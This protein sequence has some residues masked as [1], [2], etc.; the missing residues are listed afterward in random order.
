[1]RALPHRRVWALR[2]EHRSQVRAWAC[3]AA[4]TVHALL[5]AGTHTAGQADL[6][7]GQSWASGYNFTRVH[8]FH[9]DICKWSR[10]CG[11]HAR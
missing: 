11:A 6:S 7:A 9:S 2:G 1:V 10:L 4:R 8:S 5:P 3:G